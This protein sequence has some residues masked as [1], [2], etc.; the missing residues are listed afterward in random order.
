M[1][2]PSRDR[3]AYLHDRALERAPE[4]RRAFLENACN[5]DHALLD[6]VE[7]LLRYESDAA[8]FLE[9]PAAVAA[10]DLA[11]TPH[12]AEMV[13]R[14]VG[15][16]TIVA[17]LGAGGMGEVYRA[18]DSKLGRDV[19]IKMLP[20]HLIADP[21]RRSR[22]A[23]EARLLATLN[24]PHIGAIYGVEDVDGLAALILELVEG[25]TLADRLAR[26][27]LPIAEALA[28][29]RQLADALDAAHEHG[30]VHR[31]LKPANIVL[32]GAAAA[33]EFR[34]SDPHAKVL[35]FGLAKTI[36]VS[37]GDGVTQRPSGSGDITADGRILGTPAYMSPEQARG[38]AVDKRTDIWAFGCVLYEMLAGRPPFRGDTMSDTFVSILEREPDW[39]ALPAPK[40]PPPIRTLLERCLRKDPRKRLR[41]IADALIEIDDGNKRTASTASAFDVAPEGSA[42]GRERLGWIVA[43]ALAL[44]LGGTALLTS[45]HVPPAEPKVVEFPLLPPDGFSFRQRAGDFAVSPDGQHVAFV[46][47]SKAGS[48]LWV[49]S[50]AAVDPRPLPGTEGARHPFWSPDSQ[51]IG[52]FAANQLRTVQ[53]SG[54]SAVVSFPWAGAFAWP[55]ESAGFAPG[56]TWSSKDVVVFGPSSQGDLYQVNVKNGGTPAPVTKGGATASYRWPVF[57]PDGEH[58]LYAS[59]VGTT[60]ELRVGSLTMVDTVV[61][62]TFESMGLY[63]AGHLFFRRGSNLMAQPFDEKTLQLHGDPVLLD[64][65]IRRDTL[66]G[67]S[68][69]A[70]GRLVFVRPPTAQTQLAWR[71]RD[72]RPGETVGDPGALGNLD[73]SPDDRQLTLTKMTPRPAGGVQANIWLMD[74]TTGREQRLTDDPVGDYDPTWSPDGKHIVFN[75]PRPGRKG[76]FLRASDGSGVDVPL[77]TSET[78]TFT[79]ASWSRTHVLIFNAFNKTTASDLWT[80]TMSGNR[81]REVFLSSKYSELN[82]TFSPDGRWVAYQSNASGRYEVLVRPFPKK[83]PALIIS[84][85][86][87]MYP[88]WRGDGKELF[89]VSPD[90]T[91]MAIGFDPTSGLPH[92][93]P[94]ALFSTQIWMGDNRPYAVDRNGERFLLAIAPDPRVTV[95]M[96]WRTLV[97]ATVA[98]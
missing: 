41:D 87:G 11:R 82:G 70:N 2:T 51:S 13:G 26:G 71:F 94:R 81:T 32:Q 16:Y 40:T 5:G 4:E 54:Q 60:H 75:S 44:A 1:D 29:A 80:M 52:F 79:V 23:R 59:F 74:P 47:I 24:H 96:D 37:L 35:D 3:I 85:N 56:G 73:L 90:G 18:H 25:P 53:A 68:V 39:A 21:E 63:A 89:F 95:V 88:R 20:S 62:G 46:A 28:I 15:P 76:L 36:A 38:Q 61:T 55:A 78:D 65:Q 83:D 67:F 30:I 9:T 42:R 48:S 92:G 34:S 93:L 33:S 43:A 98:R 91:M 31:D 72:G 10:G 8:R 50:L 7:S 17:P 58:F 86:G 19:A 14:R 66:P 22:F 6:E 45:R 12:R 64:M 77:A 27:A 57:L 69:S 49:R 84:R 97:N